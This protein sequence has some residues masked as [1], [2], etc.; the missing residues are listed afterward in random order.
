[1]KYREHST[2]PSLASRIEC[3]WLAEDDTAGAGPP[4]RVLPD[5]CIEWIIHLGAPYAR[6]S[7]DGEASPQPRSFIVG[8]MTRPIRIAP[9]GPVRTLGVRFRPGGAR[10]ILGLP[11]DRLTDEAVC[12]EDLWGIDG[13]RVED[14]VG[15][16]FDDASRRAVIERFLESRLAR[17]RPGSP[18]LARAVGAILA[19]RGR[20]PVTELAR[21]AGWGPRQLEREFRAGVGLAPKALSRIIRFQN[22]LL[23]AGRNPGAA[24]AD[25]AARCGFADQAHLVREFRELAGVTPAS[26]EAACGELGRYFIAPVRLEAL[27]S[28][29]TAGDVAFLQ[30]AAR[31]PA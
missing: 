20:L 18:R 15:N 11:V 17:S 28:G 4:E 31:P 7:G 5:G 24:W 19:S 2:R 14:E 21:R 16:A 29:R 12:A 3:L 13:R 26:G 30:D 27:L 8:Q 10:E 6:V 23:L 9:T 1:M 25:R 22:L